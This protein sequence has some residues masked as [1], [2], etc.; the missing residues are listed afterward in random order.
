MQNDQ[1][2]R[3]QSQSLSRASG[4]QLDMHSRAGS[5]GSIPAPQRIFPLANTPRVNE[6][7]LSSRLQPYTRESSSL[8]FDRRA[9]YSFLDYYQFPDSQIS[10][11]PSASE[12]PFG[13]MLIESQ[14]VDVSL[15]GFDMFPWLEQPTFADLETQMMTDQDMA[16]TGRELHQNEA[17]TRPPIQPFRSEGPDDKM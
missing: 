13:D 8:P 11:L 10:N 2:F 6:L 12:A 17:I 5:M 9:A 16:G 14:D 15:L 4:D 3:Q 7:D 1:A